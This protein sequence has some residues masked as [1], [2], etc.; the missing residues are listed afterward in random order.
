MVWTEIFM[1]LD[2]DSASFDDDE[3]SPDIRNVQNMQHEVAEK[4]QYPHDDDNECVE[5]EERRPRFDAMVVDED[6]DDCGG[7]DEC[8]TFGGKP[9]Q[10]ALSPVM[11]DPQPPMHAQVADGVETGLEPQQL[12]WEGDGNTNTPPTP[13]NY[14]EPCLT[15][16]L[17]DSTENHQGFRDTVAV[18][19]HGVRTCIAQL[20]QDSDSTL[21][22]SAHDGWTAELCEEYA[23]PALAHAQCVRTV[24]VLDLLQFDVLTCLLQAVAANP[25]IQSVVLAG[26]SHNSEVQ[27]SLRT[28]HCVAQLLQSHPTLEELAVTNCLHS[29]GAAGTHAIAAGVAHAPALRRLVLECN[30]MTDEALLPLAQALA[31]QHTVMHLDLA[32]NM[33][34]YQGLEML[35][36]V[37]GYNNSLCYI[38]LEGNAVHNLHDVWEGFHI[39]EE[40]AINREL[41]RLGDYTRDMH[42]RWPLPW[43]R[44]A[45]QWWR[46]QWLAKTRKVVAGCSADLWE[47]VM[48]WV[49]PR[50]AVTSQVRLWMKI[51]PQTTAAPQRAAPAP[52]MDEHT[53]W[54]HM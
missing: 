41:I 46:A 19:P 43:R 40:C 36:E 5:E 37:L 50:P 31:A 32:H 23:A 16:Y 12:E 52:V 28:T 6:F 3:K 34:A 11:C 45:L 27:M 1:G 54:R 25:R 44:E 48:Q 10:L 47:T 2:N 17:P 33:L 22:I 24:A 13:P 53:A 18:M 21:T 38:G 15:K 30:G 9:P 7:A 42:C 29:V 26:T 14:E 39:Q 20:M 51:E 4:E 49:D 35:A 8:D